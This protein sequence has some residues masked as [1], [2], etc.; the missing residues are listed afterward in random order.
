MLRR[1]AEDAQARAKRLPEAKSSDL[2]HLGSKVRCTRPARRREVESRG[3]CASLRAD[4]GG[5]C[6]RL[7]LRWY[8]DRL[9]KAELRA[10]PAPPETR[11]AAKEKV[12]PRGQILQPSRRQAHL[13][14]P[15]QQCRRAPSSRR[16]R[17]MK[18]TRRKKCSTLR[19]GGGSLRC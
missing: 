18:M 4:V 12:R 9:V 14:R 13:F 3:I 15:R 8:H 16:R 17:R 10:P 1:R 19:G 2:K 5:R 7:A 11:A 6:A